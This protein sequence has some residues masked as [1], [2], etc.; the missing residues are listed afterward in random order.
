MKTLSLSVLS[1]LAL[2]VSLHAQQPIPPPD[3][4][5]PLGGLTGGGLNRN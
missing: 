1:I 4:T 2:S 5:F 3:T